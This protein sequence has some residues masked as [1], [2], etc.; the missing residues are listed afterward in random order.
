MGLTSYNYKI[1]VPPASVSGRA[2]VGAIEFAL[3]AWTQVAPIQFK[4]VNDSPDL[5]FRF[6]G[7]ITN[8][9]NTTLNILTGVVPPG[10]SPPIGLTKNKQITFNPNVLWVNSPS[11]LPGFTDMG[12]TALHEVGHYLGLKHSTNLE[13][14]MYPVNQGVRSLSADDIERIQALKG[15]PPIP[16]P[17]W[18][19]N[20]TSGA[21]VVVV[22]LSRSGTT[23][24]VIVG[25]IDNPDGA[26]TAYYRVG[27]DI[28]ANGNPRG[29]WSPP[30]AMGGPL[31]NDSQG[32][33][34]ATGFIHGL[35]PDGRS[36]LDM[37][38]MWMDDP[39]GENQLLYRVG[40]N[41]GE[42][43][44]TPTWTGNFPVPGHFGNTTEEVA[45]ALFDVSGSGGADL[46]VAWI[47]NPDG[48]NSIYYKIGYDIAAD[49]SVAV[50]SDQMS[51]PH[52]VGFSSSG[53]GISVVDTRGNGRPDMLVFWIDNP[54]GANN[55]F[56]R[57]GEDLDRDGVPITGWG[58]PHSIP[59][60]WGNETGGAGAA[61]ANIRET[62][63]PDVIVLT[64]DAPD[65]PDA[66]Y[67]RVLSPPMP[68]WNVVRPV[69]NGTGVV[70]IAASVLPEA[71]IVLASRGVP[72]PANAPLQISVWDQTDLDENKGSDILEFVGPKPANDARVDSN[73]AVSARSTSTANVF[74]VGIDNFIRS[75]FST[76]IA[77]SGTA[78]TG[79][80]W[81]LPG[82]R[83]P[84]G[85]PVRPANSAA[86]P[87]VTSSPLVASSLNDQH[88]AVFFAGKEDDLE[89]VASNGAVGW[90]AGNTRA[91]WQRPIVAIAAV[92]RAGRVFIIVVDGAGAFWELSVDDQVGFQP[93][94]RIIPAGI[95]DGAVALV[96]RNNEQ[97]DV[98]WIDKVSRSPMSSFWNTAT[99]LWSAPFAIAAG[100]TALSGSALAVPNSWNERL[101]VFWQEAD[102][103]VWT[104]WWA[105]RP[106]AV[107]ATWS[108]PS[109]AVAAG[110]A[111][112]G[113][114]LIA[115]SRKAEHVRL[116]FVDSTSTL[117]NVYW[118]ENP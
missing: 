102:S 41:L 51:V 2:I 80:I 30:I 61:F 107:P 18:F 90:V 34:L 49:G 15:A 48:E 23:L 27:Y 76:T 71:A 12:S 42:D 59:G 103:S 8:S 26:D 115:V 65:G 44:L 99:G 92:P 13:S 104:T 93:P 113:S 109:L 83:P 77:Q 5:R 108:T 67:I 70:K 50:W 52:P 81:L 7:L 69:P 63:R 106:N 68:T 3:G 9:D 89:I 91:N 117:Q 86:M 36:S 105:P 62:L 16:V 87:P 95:A 112:A 55:A 38:M 17:G 25:Q 98:F 39:S 29:G 78:A 20:S 114:D 116:F 85:N 75:G 21:D 54:D 74:Y 94:Q 47:D 45:C 11:P 58:T 10:V 24:D 33:G 84:V 96:S 35:L 37:V 118:G 31:G 97:L 88:V 79:P 82:F 40:F 22:D 56:V 100:R 111:A 64:L 110:V 53:L 72:G 28:D 14:A 1:D 101:Q 4:L 57:I 19:G 43:G 73:V 6:D 66:A 32:L 60:S 46:I